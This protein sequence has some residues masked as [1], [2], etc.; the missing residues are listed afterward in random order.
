[1]TSIMVAVAVASVVIAV[2]APTSVAA[3][4]HPFAAIVDLDA[5]E[6]AANVSSARAALATATS[7]SPTASSTPSP[8][9]AVAELVAAWVDAL[10]DDRAATTAGGWGATTF[11]RLRAALGP[12]DGSVA[13]STS[14]TASTG[15][16][17]AVASGTLFER[18]LSELGLEPADSSAPAASNAPAALAIEIGRCS[19]LRVR[20]LHVDAGG[21]DDGDVLGGAA[22]RES[23]LH[24][25]RGW[26]GALGFRTCAATCRDGVA[27]IV[28]AWA[29][30]SAAACTAL[31]LLSGTRLFD[32]RPL[33]AGSTTAAAVVSFGGWSPADPSLLDR[34]P[35]WFSD[36]VAVIAG[37][38]PSSCFPEAEAASALLA[39]VE[40]PSVHDGTEDAGQCSDF[41][42]SVDWEEFRFAYESYIL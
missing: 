30:R 13:S 27:R 20:R 2:A 31:H 25:A 39:A 21:C 17:A 26:A 5:P 11:A 42:D 38:S 4:P 24:L 18:L 22:A 23:P 10:A 37:D 16:G 40:S 15:K 3:M 7:A 28:D 34:S 1:M 29:D 33:G 8:T 14:H 41:L 6:W 35:I 9:S 12:A 32:G 36:D 19:G